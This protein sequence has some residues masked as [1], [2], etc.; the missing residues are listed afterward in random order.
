MVIT[1]KRAQTFFNRLLAITGLQTGTFAPFRLSDV[2]LVLSESLREVQ[3]VVP[4]SDEEE[5]L[6]QNAEAQDGC[7]VLE[8]RALLGLLRTRHPKRDIRKSPGRILYEAYHVE[9]TKFDSKNPYPRGCWSKLDAPRATSW[10]VAAKVL[11]EALTKGDV[12]LFNMAG[13]KLEAD[14]PSSKRV[15][16]GL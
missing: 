16:Y 11:A 2:A 3:E 1:D 10:E 6:V 8:A 9:L 15:G 12:D 5:E 13:N 14:K 7:T 4:L